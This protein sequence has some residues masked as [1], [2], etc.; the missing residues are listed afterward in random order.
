MTHIGTLCKTVAALT[1]TLVL[2]ACAS[3]DTLRTSQDGELS[4]RGEHP[5]LP[6]SSGRYQ[7]TQILPAG[8]EVSKR[9]PR[10]QLDIEGLS[11]ERRI[12]RRR[13]YTDS[14]G[15][16]LIEMPIEPFA[17]AEEIQQAMN[18][19]D[20][21]IRRTRLADNYLEIDG[22]EWLQPR[23]NVLFNRRPVIEVYFYALGNG[24]Q[25]HMQH[26]DE[27]EPFPVSVQ[28]DLLEQLYAALP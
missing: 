5:L 18:E 11:E 16:P 14:N 10:K 12:E 21:R 8:T 2:A 19:L 25:V 13:L 23:R 27:D 3:Q 6:A 28:R 1:V 15:L 9:A 22:S 20:W 24:T 17:A 26:R 4:W 7:M